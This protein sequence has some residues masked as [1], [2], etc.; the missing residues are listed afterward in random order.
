MR[1]KE[2]L[3]EMQLSWTKLSK[4]QYN[5]AVLKLN[6]THQLENQKTFVSR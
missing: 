2:N 1:Q 5:M 3:T 4:N 6:N